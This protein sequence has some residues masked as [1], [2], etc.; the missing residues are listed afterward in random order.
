M[1]VCGLIAV[2]SLSFQSTGSMHVAFS[3]FGSQALERRLRGCD[4]WA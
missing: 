2:A 1:L 3:G 4:P